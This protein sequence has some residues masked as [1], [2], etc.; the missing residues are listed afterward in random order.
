MGV[1]LSLSSSLSQDLLI[2]TSIN[3]FSSTVS[4]RQSIGSP[5]PSCASDKGRINILI[6]DR[7][8]GIR[9]ESIAITG[10]TMAAGPALHSQKLRAGSHV[11]P[12]ARVALLLCTG[13]ST[14]PALL[15]ATVDH[16]GQGTRARA[17]FLNHTAYR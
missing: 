12:P 4:S 6:H 14:G 17:P 11:F 5:L 2:H 7:R 9:G 15:N 13:E 16:G 8:Q 3:R 10:Q 1:G